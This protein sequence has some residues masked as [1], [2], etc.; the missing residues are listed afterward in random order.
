MPLIDTT[1]EIGSIYATAIFTDATSTSDSDWAVDDIGSV[2]SLAAGYEILGGT[3]VAL[4][5]LT[6]SIG[7][8]VGVRAI[9]THLSA[10]AKTTHTRLVSGAKTARIWPVDS[11]KGH[12]THSQ[13]ME[14]ASLDNVITWATSVTSNAVCMNVVTTTA[15]Q[16]IALNVL[17]SAYGNIEVGDALIGEQGRRW[18]K[19]ALTPKNH[20]RQPIR[21]HGRGAQFSDASPAELTALQ[22]LRQMVSADDFRRY[23]RHGFVPVRAESGLTYQVD[24]HQ[25]ISVWDR[26]ER[27]ASLCVHLRGQGLPPT[28]EVVAKIIM[29]ECDEADIW[30]RSNVSWFAL[31]DRPALRQLGLAATA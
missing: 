23:L 13:I 28:D 30:K 20:R 26:G 5:A 14:L 31:R 10:A 16:T 3:G 2:T 24:R 22:L 17:S 11:A 7:P 19:P 21:S 29:I 9:R 12:L 4:G 15:N 1:T 18:S 25:R 8:D 27:V 6:T